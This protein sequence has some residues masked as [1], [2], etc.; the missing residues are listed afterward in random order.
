MHKKLVLPLL[1][2]CTTFAPAIVF[3]TYASGFAAY[4]T[5]D[6]EKAYAEWA[7]LA[8]QG[9][10]GSQFGLGLLYSNG[11]G[12]AQDD[13]AALKWYELAANQ[14]HA[15]AQY[16][17]SVMYQNGWGVDQSDAEALKWLRLA[18]GNGFAAA[19]RGL[20]D[21]YANGI[22]V[23][24]DNVQAYQWYETGT[25]LGDTQSSFNLQELEA[26]M[27]ANEITTAHALAKTWID[28]FRVQHPDHVWPDNP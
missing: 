10:A 20:G 4:S 15:E 13:A 21:L 12:V 16:N 19:H 6:Y 9:D 1:L 14:G 23:P 17:I 3:G 28:D 18:A 22:G 2:L 25:A 5:G 26:I 27:Q 24:M 7:P 8:E 11:W